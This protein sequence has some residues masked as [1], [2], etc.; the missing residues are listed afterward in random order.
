MA[1]SLTPL[2]IYILGE[3]ANITMGNSATTLSLMVQHKVDITTPKVEVIKRSASLDDYEKFSRYMCKIERLIKQDER[4]MKI[5]H[6]AQKR[7]SEL[8]D[9][10]LL[11]I[12]LQNAEAKL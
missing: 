9:Q 10:L 5:L 4:E 7:I 2:Q 11:T 12:K 8:Q 1:D 6:A 3:I